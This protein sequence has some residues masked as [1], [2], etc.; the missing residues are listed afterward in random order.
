M[1]ITVI[2]DQSL[3]VSS[4]ELFA[5]F[6]FF[7][8]CCFVE[9]VMV[10]IRRSPTTPLSSGIVKQVLWPVESFI[11]FLRVSEFLSNI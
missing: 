11:L 5:F 4:S 7:Y 2:S 1:Q 3:S 10:A 6:S 9:A 8:F